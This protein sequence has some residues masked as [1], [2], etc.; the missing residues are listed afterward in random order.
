MHS[1]SPIQGWVVEVIGPAG[2]CRHPSSVHFG[3][4]QSVPRQEGMDC[5]HGMIWICVGVSTQLDLLRNPSV[6]PTWPDEP[7]P[8]T[9]EEQQLHSKFP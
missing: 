5:A 1:L 8:C 7:P 4:S 3:E 6:D 9:V 2:K